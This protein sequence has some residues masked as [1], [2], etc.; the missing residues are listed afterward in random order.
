MVAAAARGFAQSSALASRHFLARAFFPLVR[1]RITH[2]CVQRLRAHRPH[3]AAHGVDDDRAAAG[4]AGRAAGSDGTW[5]AGLRGTRVC[6]AVLELASR[7]AN[8]THAD[9]S[10][11][12]IAADGYRDV[13]LAHP[14]LYELALRSPA[15]H[16]VEHACFFV[17]SLIFWWPVVQPW[18]SKAQWP[19]W[20]MVP[21]L[22]IADLQNT[23]LSAILV[24]SDRVLYPSYSAVPRLFGFSALEDQIA[25]GAIMWVV[26]SLAFIVPAIVIAVQCLSRKPSR[27]SITPVRR[28]ETTSLDAL[29]QAVPFLS[30]FL[31]ARWRGERIEAISFVVLFAVTC[32]C[33]AGLLTAGSND[34]DNQALRFKGASG[35][36]TVAVFASCRRS[37][38]W[39]LALQRAGPGPEYSQRSCSIRRSISRHIRLATRMV[40]LR[41]RTPAM[42]IPRTSCC[43][44][45]T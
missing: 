20:A 18:P 10:G 39:F 22:L 38:R 13:R 1:A 15:W 16:Q 8:R 28:R 35:P 9:A 36:F 3:A 24:F 7:R 26:G 32:L 27:E 42:R 6:R 33:F 43:K 11:L 5:A 34:D 12:R 41:P 45:R 2:G 17:T 30:R 19:R 40:H 14:A 25:A 29:P 21:Y 31:P 23:A 37:H 4:P 44:P